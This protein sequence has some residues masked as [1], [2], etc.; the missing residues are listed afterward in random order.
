M[1]AGGTQLPNEPSNS[2]LAVAS[3]I[4]GL[5]SLFGILPIFGGAIAI[6]LGYLAK[7][8]IDGSLGTLK[9]ANLAT[10]GQIMGA[11]HIVGAFVLF[12]CILAWI[13]V[14]Q[15]IFPSGASY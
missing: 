8:E 10:A 3:L 4:V 9:G 12:C 13:L 6:I 15:F 14:G 2:K 7:S 11:V 1:S 5:I